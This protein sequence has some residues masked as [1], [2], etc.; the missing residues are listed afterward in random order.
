MANNVELLYVPDH[1]HPTTHPGTRLRTVY[2]AM[3]P[4]REGT[5]FEFVVSTPSHNA[6]AQ[7][8]TQQ[9]VRKHVM[10]PWKRRKPPPRTVILQDEDLAE[11][12]AQRQRH[13]KASALTY[14]R[15]FAHKLIQWT[16][17]PLLPLRPHHP[18]LRYPSLR[19]AL[20]MVPT[21]SP[22]IAAALLG[23][24]RSNP[25][26]RYPINMS[27]RELELVHHSKLL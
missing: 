18:L 6:A 19:G 3:R 25:F 17:P 14:F 1:V 24:S 15:Y 8:N 27:S 16:A 4:S 2:S 26:G 10:R 7:K 9:L 21:G 13:R 20:L 22:S 23:A 11:Y 5:K 12:L